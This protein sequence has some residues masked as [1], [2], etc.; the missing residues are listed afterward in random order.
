MSYDLKFVINIPYNRNDYADISCPDA[1]VPAHLPILRCEHRKEAHINQSR[2]PSTTARAY[3]NY[4]TKV[5]V[6]IFHMYEYC[7][8]WHLQV[9][10]SCP[11]SI[12]VDSFSWLMNPRRLIYKFFFSHM[13]G[14]ILLYCAILSVGF[15][16]HQIHCQWQM[17]RRMKQVPVVSTTNLHVNVATVLSWWTHLPGWIT[18][19]FFIVWF[20]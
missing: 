5:W 3:Y 9:C 8:I 6:I 2:H 10:F 4:C 15:F 14:M 18:H 19:Q 11:S 20:L 17:S 7:I 16:H 13:T 1:P 12:G